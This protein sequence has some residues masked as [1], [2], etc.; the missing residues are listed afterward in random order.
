[1]LLWRCSRRPELCHR[2]SALQTGWDLSRPETVAWVEEELAEHPPEL[3]VLSP[4]CTD[5]GG[6]FHLNSTVMDRIEVL[7]RRRRVRQFREVC[8]RLIRPMPRIMSLTVTHR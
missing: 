6:W 5:T 8:K 4:P 3:L 2:S 1:M 7:R